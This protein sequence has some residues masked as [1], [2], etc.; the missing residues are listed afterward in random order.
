[1]RWVGTRA[2]IE[3]PNGSSNLT[4]QDDQGGDRA[5]DQQR[6]KGLKTMARK[7]LTLALLGIAALLISGC[8]GIKGGTTTGGTGGGTGGT[9]GGGT[10][11]TATIGGNLTGLATGASGW[12]DASG[13]FWLFGGWGLDATA[14]NGNGAL[15]DLWVYVPNSVAGQPGTWTWIKGSNTGGQNGV[16]GDEVRPYKTYEIWTPGGP[17]NATRWVDNLGQ[18]WLFGG[19]GYDSTSTTGNGSLNDMWRYLSY[20]D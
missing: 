18:L 4:E 11:V 7:N 20:P 8:S 3:S 15:N 10:S 19:Q 9:G 17:S 12:T 1:M 5:P 14:T 13:N 2:R 6:N 16:Y